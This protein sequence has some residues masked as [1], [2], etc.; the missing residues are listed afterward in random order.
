MGCDHDI[1]SDDDGADGLWW[2]SATVHVRVGAE[3]TNTGAAKNSAEEGR[4]HEAVDR[5]TQD[6]NCEYQLE[7]AE[8]GEVR[9][10]PCDVGSHEDCHFGDCVASSSCP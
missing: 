10:H 1:G 4:H 5:E 8:N 9:R 2:L 6:Q 7:N 3:D